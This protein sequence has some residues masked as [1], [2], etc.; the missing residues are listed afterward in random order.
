MDQWV[1]AL[2]GAYAADGLDV[3]AI[4]P[5]W[6]DTPMAGDFTA[7]TGIPAAAL[8]AMNALGV[9][10]SP[11]TVASVVVAMLDRDRSDGGSGT[12]LPSGSCVAVEGNGE[13]GAV[14]WRMDGAY[15]SMAL[16]GFR[17]FRSDTGRAMDARG[18]VLPQ[19]AV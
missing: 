16:P 10:A 4:N 14:L 3:Y 2:A 6:V 15:A 18:V 1:R 7:A 9:L 13:T 19:A 8:G 5:Y 12:V 11:E 17:A